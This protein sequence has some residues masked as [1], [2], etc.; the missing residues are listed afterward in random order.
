MDHDFWVVKYCVIAYIKDVT[1]RNQSV[2]DIADKI[3]MQQSRLDA[4]GINF[5]DKGSKGSVNADAI[6]NGVATIIELKQELETRIAANGRDYVDAYLI[7]TRTDESSTVWYHVSERKKWAEIGRM[8]G[9]SE[10]NIRKMA[11]KGYQ[12]I[13]DAMPEIYRRYTLPNAEV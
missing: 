7:C 3:R 5:D 8:M 11:Q 1:H 9:Y 12:E 13:Y 4:M 6:E 10:S 2:N